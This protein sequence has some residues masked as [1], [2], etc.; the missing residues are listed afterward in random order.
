MRAL[1]KFQQIGGEVAVELVMDFG[2]ATQLE[3]QI[4]SEKKNFG[5]FI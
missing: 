3:V 4:K 1:K 2:G 5:K